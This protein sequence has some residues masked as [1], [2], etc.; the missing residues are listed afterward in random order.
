[1]NIYEDAHYPWLKTE[2]I[3]VA[4]D[5]K[6]HRTAVVK[7]VISSKYNAQITRSMIA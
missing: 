3:I 5:D 2:K 4:P 6:F 1:M 7:D